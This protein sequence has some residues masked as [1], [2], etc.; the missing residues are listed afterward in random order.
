MPGRLLERAGSGE[1]A[2]RQ[3]SAPAATFP[4]RRCRSAAARVRLDSVPSVVR[5]LPRGSYRPQLARIRGTCHAGY[6]TGQFSLAPTRKAVGNSRE[7]VL[8]RNRMK[9]IPVAGSVR[10]RD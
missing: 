8:P 5:D 10:Q 4:E 1:T 3:P 2:P 9:A 6:G 7:G